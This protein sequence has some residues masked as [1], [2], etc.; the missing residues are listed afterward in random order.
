MGLKDKRNIFCIFKARFL[1]N[2]VINVSIIVLKT[3]TLLFIVPPQYAQKFRKEWEKVP[4]LAGWIEPATTDPKRTYCKYCK[5]L[6]NAKLSDLIKHSQTGKHVAAARP[7]SCRRQQKIQFQTSNEVTKEQ[8][9]EGQ[10]ALYVAMHASIASVDHLSDLHKDTP[11]QISL[12]RTKCTALIKNVIGPY[13]FESLIKDVGNTYY[14]LLIDESTD[15]TVNKM[16]GIVIRYYSLE[17][18]RIV[19]TFL[20][21]IEIEDGPAECIVRAMKN[22][23]S[24]AKL[25]LQ[26]MQSIGTDNASTMVGINSGV[27]ARLKAKI[28]HLTLI[29]CVC[30]SLQLAVSKSTEKTLPRNVEFLVEETYNWFAHSSI[31]QLNYSQLYS[32][33]ND[34]EEPLKILRVA[35]TRWL[36]IEPA[37]NR[38]LDQWLS[39]KTHFEISRLKENCYN[40]EM[41][42]SMYCDRNNF[43]FLT[44]LHPILN[45]VQKTNKNFESKTADSTK[46]LS[47]VKW[48]YSTVVNKVILPTARINIFENDIENHLDPSPALGFAFE[49]ACQEHAICGQDKAVLKSRCVA[50]L[51]AL[52]KELKNRLPQSL[53]ILEKM[54]AFSVSECLKPNKLP[55]T[56]VASHFVTNDARSTISQV[57]FQWD[58]LRSINWKETKDT[59]KFWTEVINYRDSSGESPFKHLNDLALKVLC[60]PHSNADIER[61]FSQM[62]LVKTKLRNK[63]KLSLLNNILHIRFGVKRTGS[64]CNDFVLPNE[65]LKSIGTLKVYESVGSNKDDCDNLE[66]LLLGNSPV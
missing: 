62:N 20:G 17:N 51:V 26:N 24:D 58:N 22:M 50:F 30:H 34:G 45:L 36:S 4:A 9:K 44:F 16:L 3:S 61:I 10:L 37:V 5:V 11:L 31:R 43:V 66:G 23:L 63:M 64:C 21:L 33:I 47:D 1:N 18:M 6:L 49:S 32:T 48:L 29:R 42:Y 7:F 28:P 2:V 52:A 53:N 59:E 40:A 35:E 56:D 55:I 41:L 54:N 15:I 14:S 13:F 38:I 57:E 60:L 12:H 39:L 19:S 46:L 27:Y 25:N 65:V 8:Q